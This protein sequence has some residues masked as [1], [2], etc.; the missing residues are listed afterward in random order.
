M[1]GYDS[2]LEL[3][4][5][6]MYGSEASLAPVQLSRVRRMRIYQNP[7]HSLKKLVLP[8][9]RELFFDGDDNCP[10]IANPQLQQLLTQ[11]PLDLSKVATLMIRK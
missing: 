4:A 11:Y 3:L 7:I 5:V 8:E 10:W 1:R 6:Y 2:Y 9:L